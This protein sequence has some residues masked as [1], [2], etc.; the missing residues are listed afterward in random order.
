[1]PDPSMP[2]RLR[3]LLGR[4]SVSPRRLGPPGPSADEVAAA[5]AAGLRAPDHGGLVPWRVVLIE[6]AQRA[7]LGELFADE[8]RRRDP[9]ASAD[10]LA[11]ARAHATGVPTLLAFVACPRVGTTVPAHEQWLAAGAALMNLLNAFEA[12]GFGAI[13][14]SGERCGDA[15]LARALGLQATEVLAGFV[16][17]GNV[18]E[19][20]SPAKPKPVG[21]ALAVWQPGPA[22]VDSV[23]I[24]ADAGRPAAG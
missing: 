14:L 13:L 7:A 4:R 24:R 3:P 9:L 6:P 1:M 19:A 10:D 17:V 5:V 2:D 12:L 20:P 22:A 11:R 18:V 21:D 15:L 23:E 16:S 8:K